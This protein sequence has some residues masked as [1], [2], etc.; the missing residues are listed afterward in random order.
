MKISDQ[1]IMMWRKEKRRRKT[2]VCKTSTKC[3]VAL[4]GV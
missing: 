2:A 1:F 4:C 3:D